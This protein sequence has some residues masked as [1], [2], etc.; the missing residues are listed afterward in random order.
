MLSTSY[1]T[2]LQNLIFLQTLHDKKNVSYLED[3]INTE[4]KEL[5]QLHKLKEDHK[6]YYG[7]KLNR[8]ELK[9]LFSEVKKETDDFLKV[10]DIDKPPCDYY[11]IFDF[12]PINATLLGTYLAGSF[13]STVGILNILNNPISGGLVTLTG[14]GILYLARGL[15]NFLS[16]PHYNA[17]EDNEHI[18]LQKENK[19]NLIMFLSHEY[20]HHVQGRI[21][22]FFLDIGFEFFIE[23][24][25]RGVGRHM[26]KKYMK[27]EDNGAF[28]Y[29][30]L[31]IDVSE[32][33]TTYLWLCNNFDL[34]PKKSL[35]N[36]KT[37]RDDEDMKFLKKCKMPSPHAIGNSLFLIYENKKGPGIYSDMIHGNF[38]F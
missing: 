26:S 29:N 23:G 14:L 32:M 19:E 17:K 16:D 5:E 30:A 34:T 2:P 3:I 11:N 36:T 8:K 38:K 1:L 27:E 24:H 4:S 31:N 28:L 15:H 13:L 7:P 20:T 33:K 18:I 35:L 21:E 12:K 10:T 22:G 6:L 25:A 9:D 37:L